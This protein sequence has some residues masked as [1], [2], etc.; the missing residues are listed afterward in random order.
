MTCID[1]GQVSKQE[2][3]ILKQIKGKLFQ[4]VVMYK[5]YPTFKNLK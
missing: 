1:L 5:T 2:A 4:F 3:T